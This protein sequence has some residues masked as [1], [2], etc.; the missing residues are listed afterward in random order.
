LTEAASPQP[1]LTLPGIIAFCTPAIV[2]GSY[3]VAFSVYLPQY[4]A[5]HIGISASLVGVAFAVVRGIDIWLDPFIGLAMDRT[6]TGI[7]RYRVWMLAGAPILALAAYMVF[8]TQ[9]GITL[10][11]AIFWLLIFYLG[12]SIMGLSHTSWAS[13]LAPTYNARSRLFGAMSAVGVLGAATILAM[14][15]VL[16]IKKSSDPDLLHTMGWFMIIAAPAGALLAAVATRERMVSSSHHNFKLV[17]Y[18]RLFKRPEVLRILAADLCLALGPGWMGALYLFFWKDSRQFSAINA[19]QLLGIYTVA[20]LV[21]AVAL[22]RLATIFGKHRTLMAASTGYSLGLSLLFF[23]PKGI[24]L[25]DA[26]FMFVMGFLATGFT[27]LIRAMVADVGDKVRLETGRNQMGLLYALVVG[28]QKLAGAGSIL[29]TFS[30]LD[31]VGYKTKEGVTNTVAAI[32]GL[33]LIYLIGPVL[34][35]MLGGACFIG[36]RLDSAQHA[37]IRQQLEERDAM[38]AQAGVIEAISSDAS[39]PGAAIDPPDE[40]TGQTAR[41]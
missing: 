3:A 1:P 21:G 13:V 34:F 11:Y 5:S 35:V 41:P 12:T 4:Y 14:P 24:F 9:P 10:I 8:M 20:G 33:E 38:I 17:E 27:L 2:L 25:V 26:P 29:F 22:G 39:V 15:T 31:V 18:W 7:G 30:L 36:Y 6:R 40:R 23:M 28:T 16:G 19:S 32:H 37:S